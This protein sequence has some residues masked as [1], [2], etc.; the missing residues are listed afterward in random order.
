MSATQEFSN[1]LAETPQ[2]PPPPEGPRK[3]RKEADPN[4]FFVDD[5]RKVDVIAHRLA[6][7]TAKLLQ[8]MSL[9]GRLEVVASLFR[10]FVPEDFPQELR[11][12]REKIIS[13]SEKEGWE[14][15]KLVRMLYDEKIL[16]LLGQGDVLAGA[17]YIIEYVSA[18]EHNGNFPLVLFLKPIID[19]R[20]KMSDGKHIHAIL[21]TDIINP[22]TYALTEHVFANFAHYS[23]IDACLPAIATLGYVYNK[24]DDSNPDSGYNKFFLIYEGSPAKRSEP[25]KLFES[26]KF[27]ELERYESPQLQE[28]KTFW[29]DAFV[30]Y[31]SYTAY[32]QQADT[33]YPLA[34]RGKYRVPPNYKSLTGSQDRGD[35]LNYA[36]HENSSIK[37]DKKLESIATKY[38]GANPEYS[39]RIPLAF[40]RER[41]H[42]VFGYLPQ[43]LELYN[44]DQL[45]MEG[46]AAELVTFF[47]NGQLLEAV[48][49][50]RFFSLSAV[51]K[52]SLI[53]FFSFTSN[54]SVIKQ[55]ERFVKSLDSILVPLLNNHH[56]LRGKMYN[57]RFAQPVPELEYEKYQAASEEALRKLHNSKE[58]G[59]TV[60]SDP[61]YVQSLQQR[62]EKFLAVFN[63]ARK[64]IG[65]L[66]RLKE[67][68]R[69]QSLTNVLI[70]LIMGVSASIVDITKFNHGEIL[71][72]SMTPLL[73]S[74]LVS[75]GAVMAS[76]IESR[77][78]Q[79]GSSLRQ[80]RVTKD[81]S[82][83]ELQFARDSFENDLSKEEKKNIGQF[84]NTL[85]IYLLTFTVVSGAY[86][87]NGMDTLL[88]QLTD[89]AA[90]TVKLAVKESLDWIADTL[91]F[92]SSN[93]VADKSN[94]IP[95]LS[96][97]S[98]PSH[99][100]AEFNISN[101]TPAEEDARK[102]KIGAHGFKTLGQHKD[103]F[104]ADGVCYGKDVTDVKLLCKNT[105]P[106]LFPY[107]NPITYGLTKEQLMSEITDLIKNPNIVVRIND[108][109]NDGHFGVP[110]GYRLL[111]ILT[112]F[113]QDPEQVA[114]DQLGQ[115]AYVSPFAIE[116][117]GWQG[118]T[119]TAAVF[120][121]EADTNFVVD[122]EEMF[123]PPLIEDF[124]YKIKSP[125]VKKLI[126][127]AHELHRSNTS[128]YDSLLILK[129]QLENLGISYGHQKFPN[130]SQEQIGF[131]QRTGG[132]TLEAQLEELFAKNEDGTFKYP[133]WDCDLFSFA[134]YAIA[135][136]GDYDVQLIMGNVQDDGKQGGYES[137]NHMMVLY[138]EESWT[139]YHTFEATLPS[140]NQ[141]A[142]QPVQEVAKSTASVSQE[143][144]QLENSETFV[145]TASSEIPDPL[146]DKELSPEELAAIRRQLLISA[147]SVFGLGILGLGIYKVREKINKEAEDREYRKT[148]TQI[149]P[150]PPEPRSV[151][152]VQPKP[153][154]EILQTEISTRREISERE[155]L[156]AELYI[157]L[158]NLDERGL[159]A[160]WHLLLSVAGLKEVRAIT[161][162]TNL[163]E[164]WFDFHYGDSEPSVENASLLFKDFLELLLSNQN[165]H[166]S[167]I[168][169]MK[170]SI[171]YLVGELQSQAI[172]VEKRSALI[173]AI[174]KKNIAEVM[175]DD[176]G[177]RNI[178]K[179]LKLMIETAPSVIEKLKMERKEKGQE[180]TA[181][182]EARVKTA[183]DTL[184]FF[185]DASV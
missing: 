122:S 41:C 26:L 169:S 116:L 2:S 70:A 185:K 8:A 164:K 21:S 66:M 163:G 19:T 96:R 95:P 126:D 58:Q 13:Y 130:L 45:R 179:S 35:A 27:N 109:A 158:A 88:G 74:L 138:Q 166:E 177:R 178:V 77:S 36:E 55:S 43:A 15:A 73:A 92:E 102:E 37:L 160:V 103:L 155:K 142:R 62:E 20:E 149:S 145:N 106:D 91:D 165:V 51:E 141:P 86:E 87:W 49:G 136:Y 159:F 156:R 53:A 65:K 118:D 71:P 31:W 135:Q 46:I 175:A 174:N 32:T 4:D 167:K 114:S 81:M 172:N 52:V 28:L 110:T 133:E 48:F 16:N 12:I 90:P 97:P 5:P 170:S 183:L 10:T 60:K 75:L 54:G 150:R 125:E 120:V 76:N 127:L 34:A 171:N 82:D 18:N 139:G 84:R 134:L 112:T 59:I 22:F 124:T 3:K 33:A 98:T 168:T 137:N 143:T 129:A 69:L 11:K 30:N 180:L 50:P 153:R 63:V 17:Q 128:T 131:F 9:D 144:P 64:R 152:S 1:S 184:Q 78:H 104:W 161:D 140:R 24:F 146:T 99:T 108:N 151:T 119:S 181:T 148:L 40:N 42:K 173:D 80:F 67:V 39:K 123:F 89:G 14:Q 7:K 85:L 94:E 47:N 157:K 25:F 176:A 44:Q 23:Q 105:F 182:E 61:E 115:A 29:K 101:D 93:P 57:I 147:V 100:P 79:L 121:K 154:L 111:T 68:D 38:F 107:Q 117:T 72:R 6:N 162:S 56:L 113:S 83:R 132:F